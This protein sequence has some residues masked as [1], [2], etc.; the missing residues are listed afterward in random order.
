[1]IKR[2]STSGTSSQSSQSSQSSNFE[3]SSSKNKV[4]DELTDIGISGSL[5]KEQINEDISASMVI[6]ILFINYTINSI[7]HENGINKF[8]NKII[9]AISENTHT[10]DFFNI[11][12]GKKEYEII[13]NENFVKGF[14]HTKREK[15][16]LIVLSEYCSDRG[17]GYGF[18]QDFSLFNNKWKKISKTH[19]TW[20]YSIRHIYETDDKT[21]LISAQ[22]E[23]YVL[24][25]PDKKINNNK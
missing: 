14:I 11:D 21:I 24:I 12:S 4:S 18:A 5:E 13:D 15:N 3:D 1:M 19:S 20:S 9:G 17:G 7:F 25:Y 6:I 8:N 2:G 22:K 16:E 23:L 10:I